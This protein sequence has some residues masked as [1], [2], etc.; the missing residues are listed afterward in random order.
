M[1][2]L[3]RFTDEGQL[4]IVKRQAD[5]TI[6]ACPTGS[7]GGELL[8][9]D[10]LWGSNLILSEGYELINGLKRRMTWGLVRDRRSLTCSGKMLLVP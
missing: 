6:C 4:A 10:G 2:V 7:W 3:T 8:P 1:L 9:A 5:S